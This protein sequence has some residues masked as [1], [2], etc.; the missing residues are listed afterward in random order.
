MGVIMDNDV[1]PHDYTKRRR[2]YCKISGIDFT[3]PVFCDKA[4]CCLD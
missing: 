2:D 4:Q 1:H 3:T